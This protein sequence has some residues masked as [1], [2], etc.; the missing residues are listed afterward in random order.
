[1]KLDLKGSLQHLC[2]LPGFSWSWTHSPNSLEPLA[3][4]FSLTVLVETLHFSDN[5]YLIQFHVTL[6]G[7]FMVDLMCHYLDSKLHPY[8]GPT[9]CWI[10]MV[11]LK[12]LCF[13]WPDQLGAIHVAANIHHRDILV[14]LSL[15]PIWNFDDETIDHL[16]INCTFIKISSL[17]FRLWC[18]SFV[19]QQNGDN[20]PRK[21]LDFTTLIY[22]FLW[23]IWTAQNRKVFN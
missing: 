2:S 13:I 19:T 1:M 7:K 21:R 8:I 5:L 22:C 3:E 10:K 6:N 16:L 17:K 20:Y 12:V 4:L 23:S 14:Q 11:P 18:N 9:L 15:C